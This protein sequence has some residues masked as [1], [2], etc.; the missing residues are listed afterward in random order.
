MIRPRN[1]IATA[2]L[3]ALLDTTTDIETPEH[4]RF[5]YR[6]AGPSR[7]AIAYFF[8]LV[9]RALVLLV[10]FIFG[11]LGGL[12]DQKGGASTGVLLLIAFIVEWGYF[13]FWETIWNGQSPGKRLMKLRVVTSEGNPL[14][15]IQSVLRNLLRAADFLPNVYAVGAVVMARD[16]RFRRL[17]DL[18]AGT[19]VVAED[20]AAIIDRLEINPPPSEADLRGLP[21]RL[22]L[23]GHELETIE[24]FLRRAGRLHPHR[25]YELASLVAPVFA[26][27]LGV[28]V[29]DPARFLAILYWRASASV[30]AKRKPTK[31]KKR[32]E[33]IRDAA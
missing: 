4:V 21:T 31:K 30:P 5:R 15:F 28:R 25:Q 29:L 7:R 6:V 9:V 8:D 18:V 3:D 10:F 19:M 32:K 11:L 12:T 13:V 24:I 1:S 14:T 23:S 27:R 16:A 20:T 17:G 33:S 26:R 2:R 22:P